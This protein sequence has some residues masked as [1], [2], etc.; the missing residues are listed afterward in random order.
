MIYKLKRLTIYSFISL[1]NY[2]QK[3]V[4]GCLPVLMVRNR[5]LFQQTMSR[6]LENEEESD[7]FQS[8]VKARPRSTRL[9][10][11]ALV[12]WHYLLPSVLGHLWVV[13]KVYQ[14]YNNTHT[15]L[16]LMETYRTPSQTHEPQIMAMT[17]GR[18]IGHCPISTDLLIGQMVSHLVTNL[19]QSQTQGPLITV[20]WER[21]SEITHQRIFKVK[22]KTYYNTSF[23]IIYESTIFPQSQKY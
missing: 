14:S 20:S 5:E 12:T 7:I 21:T 13:H 2:S 6:F 11:V 4:V 23:I 9:R 22:R 16:H 15:W 8:Q 3:F 18:P 17:C 19:I 10:R 1:Q